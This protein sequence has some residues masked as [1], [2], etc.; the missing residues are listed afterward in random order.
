MDKIKFQNYKPQYKTELNSWHSKE[1]LTN[2]NGLTKFVVPEDVLLGDYIDFIENSVPDVTNL[3]VFDKSE[4]V[5]FLGFA[6]KKDNHIH[7]EYMGTNPACRGKGYAKTI[8]SE[9]KNKI[10]FKHPQTRI[11]LDVNKL[12]VNGLNSFSKVAKRSKNQ[13][14]EDYIQF[15]M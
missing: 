7:I 1:H 4:L 6:D 8:L 10:G 12:N 3:L 5:G 2:S 11:T 15:E 14:K 9:F 13:E